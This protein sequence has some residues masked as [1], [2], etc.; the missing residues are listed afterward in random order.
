MKL[1]R[2]IVPALMAMLIGIAGGMLLN[3]LE[4]ATLQ[5]EIVAIDG[6]IQ[7]RDAEI[8]ILAIN[9]VMAYKADPCNNILTYT[10]VEIVNKWLH[11]GMIQ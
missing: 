10:D 9:N 3:G 11:Y 2:L 8:L 1:K 5:A 7:S 6:D 4:V